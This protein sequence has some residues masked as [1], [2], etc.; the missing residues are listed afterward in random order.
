MTFALGAAPFASTVLF[1]AS[2]VAVGVLDHD[3]EA[4]VRA[5][6]QVALP[7]HQSSSW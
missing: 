7:H 2:G 4:A 6:D 5:L 1:P 3:A